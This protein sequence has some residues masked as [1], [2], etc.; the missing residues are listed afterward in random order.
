MTAEIIE[1]LAEM[2][3]CDFVT[4]VAARLP[5]Q[6]ICEM[7]GIPENRYQDVFDHSNVILSQG[8]MEYI[9]K[10]ENMLEAILLAGAGLAEI[11]NDLSAARLADPTDDITTILVHG[12][13]D[14]ERLTPAE[15][16]SFFVLLCTAGNETTRN[17][18]SHGL[19]ALTEHPDQRQGWLNDIDGVAKTA[20]E[21]IVR[22]ASPV[23]HFRRTVTTDGVRLG[24]KEFKAGDKVVLWYNSANRDEAVFDDPFTFDVLRNP[25]VSTGG[26]S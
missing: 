14:G 5:L 26:C 19:I 18:I 16:A 23:M 11:M 20:V 13:V 9:S 6:I 12:E 17:A 2:G 1:D 25:A 21:E 4:E 8:D 15:L 24:D 3:E 22:W 10:E 7:M